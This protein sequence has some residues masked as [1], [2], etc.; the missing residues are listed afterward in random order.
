MKPK[1]NIKLN[2]TDNER[3]YL[4]K[5]KIKI[6]EILEYTTDEIESFLKISEERA[7]VLYALA[8][9]QQIP[10]IGFE[11]AKDLVFLGFYSIDE[12]INENGP[13]LFNQFEEKKNCKV[14]PCVEDQFRLVVHFANNKDYSKNWWDFTNE[15]KVLRKKTAIKSFQN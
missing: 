11:F 6:S 12:L 15:R 9:F 7:K 10:S 4:R 1:S 2:L 5:N 14:D 3:S 8:D 13:T